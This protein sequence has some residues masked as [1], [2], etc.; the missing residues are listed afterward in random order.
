MAVSRPARARLLL[1]S[2]IDTFEALP[3][4]AA[5]SSPPPSVMH[6]TYRSSHTAPRHHDPSLRFSPLSGRAKRWRVS[7]HVQR[8][9]AQ[10]SAA[11]APPLPA[12][13]RG[14]HRA[15]RPRQHDQKEGCCRHPRSAVAAGPQRPPRAALAE[16]AEG[17]NLATFPAPLITGC[18]SPSAAIGHRYAAARYSREQAWRTTALTPGPTWIPRLPSAS[19]LSAPSPPHGPID[20]SSSS[21]PQ[22]EHAALLDAAVAVCIDERHWQTTPQVQAQLLNLH[23]EGLVGALSSPAPPPPP[24]L[25]PPPIPISPPPSSLASQPSA[26]PPASP[27]SWTEQGQPHPTRRKRRRAEERESGDKRETEGDDRVGH[28]HAHAPQRELV[29]VS[30]DAIEQ[31][32]AENELKATAAAWIRLL[33]NQRMSAATRRW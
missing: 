26:D 13:R 25:F 19:D 10:G 2:R 12:P 17:L 21:P 11:A 1:L 14:G 3:P 33:Q 5:S 8:A 24:V 16:L 18:P 32:E 7:V 15:S 30:S 23:A 22:L 28:Q 6:L 20:L 31:S 29:D 9:H 27:S 4:S